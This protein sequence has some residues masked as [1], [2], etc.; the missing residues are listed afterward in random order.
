MSALSG[1]AHPPMKFCCC[2]KS[3]WG[4]SSSSSPAAQQKMVLFVLHHRR[5]SDSQSILSEV[6]FQYYFYFYCC[7]L[8]ESHARSQVKKAMCHV[9]SSISV[10]RCTYVCTYHF[11]FITFVSIRRLIMSCNQQQDYLRSTRATSW[12][13]DLPTSIISKFVRVLY[14]V[15]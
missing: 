8:Q 11:C 14:I 12:Q 10:P 2:I 4:Y 5:T 13:Y 1:D 7:I 6:N 3:T 9:R 15:V